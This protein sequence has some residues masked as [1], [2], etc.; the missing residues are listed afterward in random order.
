M[1]P[2]VDCQAQLVLQALA[3]GGAGEGRLCG[4]DPHVFGQ[5]ALLAETL[6]AGFTEVLVLI[7]FGSSSLA[8]W[9]PLFV[10]VGSFLFFSLQNDSREVLGSGWIQI[11]EVRFLT[12]ISLLL[13]D[14]LHLIRAAALIIWLLLDLQRFWFL[15]QRFRSRDPLLVLDGNVLLTAQTMLLEA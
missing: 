7:C 8:T 15:I 14:D 1:A 5:I 4:V 3:A 11:N 13:Q 6:R 9:M 10:P 2:Q 12:G